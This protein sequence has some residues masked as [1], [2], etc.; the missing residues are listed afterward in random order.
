[1]KKFIALFVVF[2]ALLVAAEMC[3]LFVN[4]L[5]IYAAL[6]L[7]VVFVSVCTAFAFRFEKFRRWCSVAA[8]IILF[9]PIYAN[10][11]ILSY[12][13]AKRPPAVIHAGGGIYLNSLEM[14]E[15]FL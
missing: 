15:S 4:A 10:A 5:F 3:K 7:E 11:K 14:S 12:H 6:P 2:A 8:A 9:L 1:M 13:Y